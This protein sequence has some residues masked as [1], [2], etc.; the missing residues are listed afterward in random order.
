MPASLA[1]RSVSSSCSS[2]APR[3]CSSWTALRRDSSAGASIACSTPREGNQR[4]FASTHYILSVTCPLV[5]GEGHTVLAG[6]VLSPGQ[7]KRSDIH[8]A[9]ADQAASRQHVEKPDCFICR[10][11]GQEFSEHGRNTNAIAKNV[12]GLH[13]ACIPER[14]TRRLSPA[15]QDPRWR[16][17][18]SSLAVPP[19]A[20]HGNDE[21]KG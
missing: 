16:V 5:G 9:Q 15:L 17:Q 6:L 12:T 2:R 13:A 21:P 10:V 8:M 19:P 11:P 20:S 1:P 7:P 3:L 4:S 14:G 18:A